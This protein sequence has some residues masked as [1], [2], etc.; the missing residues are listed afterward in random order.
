MKRK[1]FVSLLVLVLLSAT[2][3]ICASA[4]GG[5][6]VVKGDKFYHSMFC[7]CVQEQYIDE[8]EWFETPQKA[9]SAGYI[10]CEECEASDESVYT[11]DG[12]I[13]WIPEDNKMRCILEMER[14]YGIIVGYEWWKDDLEDGETEIGIAYD[15]G[16]DAGFEDGYE[17]G[18]DEGHDE[19]YDEGYLAGNDEKEDNEKTNTVYF[20][21]AIAVVAITAFWIGKR[22]KNDKLEKELTEIKIENAKLAA[23][24]GRRGELE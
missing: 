3:P 5:V 7:D 24:V 18:Y 15:E 20:L 21:L 23:M 11:P 6:A 2:F 13:H 12:A 14:F 9:E 10:P 16:Y 22:S 8:L 19:G 4:M 17:Y 1:I